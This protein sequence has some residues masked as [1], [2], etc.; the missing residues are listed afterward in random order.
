MGWDSVALEFEG[1]CTT[2]DLNYSFGGPDGTVD[3]R[4]CSSTQGLFQE[5][6]VSY[7]LDVTGSD[8]DGIWPTQTCQATYGGQPCSCDFDFGVV[9]AVDCSSLVPGATFGAV[10]E[11]LFSTVDIGDL[12]DWFPEFDMV[13]PDFQ[14]TANAVPWETLDLQNLDFNNFD[15]TAVEWGGT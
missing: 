15:I 14:L 8:G 6:C 3:V 4:A 2:V 12:K 10:T 7:Q 5:I 13:Q 1:T 9:L 11:D